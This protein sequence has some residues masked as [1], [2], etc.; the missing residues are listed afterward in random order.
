MEILQY[1]LA[2]VSII[3]LV[4]FIVMFVDKSKAKKHAYRIPEKTLWILAIIGGAIGGVL[5]MQMFRHKTKHLSFAIGFPFLA[6][7]QIAAI[8]Y[9]AFM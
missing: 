7:I 8:I 1:I 4:L 3:S 2:Y 5:G 6:I 9:I